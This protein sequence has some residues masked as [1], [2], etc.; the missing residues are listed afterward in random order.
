M[1]TCPEKHENP[2]DA[3]F[4]RIC[5]YKFDARDQRPFHLKHPEYH[6]KPFSEFKELGFLRNSPEY[7]E[8]PS[9]SDVNEYYWIVRKEKFGILYWHHEDHWYG[10]TNNY[11]RI[12]QCEYDKIEKL[13]GMFA[14]HKGDD[15]IYIDRQGVILS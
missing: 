4:C 11:N 5:G 3:R 2:D 9:Q 12:I 6:L 15:I 8:D 10:D 7:V 13:D 14:C 1:K